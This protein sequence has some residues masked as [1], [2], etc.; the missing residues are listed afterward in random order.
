MT[1]PCPLEQ[2]TV[3]TQTRAES[4]EQKAIFSEA[5]PGKNKIPYTSVT[6]NRGSER[7]AIL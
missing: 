3:Q 1:V 2:E 7:A 6:Q 4:S 5:I